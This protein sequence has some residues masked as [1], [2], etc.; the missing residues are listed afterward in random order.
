M[1][2][3]LY[4]TTASMLLLAGCATNIPNKVPDKVTTSTEK[5]ATVVATKANDKPQNRFHI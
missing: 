2:E 3:K 4:V 5:L 1:L